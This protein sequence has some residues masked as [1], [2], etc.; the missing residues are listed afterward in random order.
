MNV[1]NGGDYV[2]RF[3]LAGLVYAGGIVAA[4]Y[5]PWVQL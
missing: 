1:P 3:A 5:W 2:Y 4:L